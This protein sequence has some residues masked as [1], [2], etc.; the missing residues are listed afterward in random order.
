MYLSGSKSTLHNLRDGFQKQLHRSQCTC[1]QCFEEKIWYYGELNRPKGA[2][3]CKVGA[4]AGIVGAGVAALFVAASN[5]AVVSFPKS[6]GGYWSEGAD[7]AKAIGRCVFSD[8]NVHPTYSCEILHKKILSLCATSAYYE[9]HIG[10]SSGG[11][12][13]YLSTPESAEVSYPQRV[14]YFLSDGQFHDGRNYYKQSVFCSSHGKETPIKNGNRTV[15]CW[16]SDLR[17]LSS[18]RSKVYFPGHDTSE[19]R[20]S[21]SLLYPGD[22][23]IRAR[24]QLFELRPNRSRRKLISL[25]AP[26]LERT[27]NV[28]FSP[29]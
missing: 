8:K 6:N 17:H 19:S 3:N 7:I 23:D 9:D 26:E 12:S 21:I 4:I 15:D 22:P 27:Y 2:D 29:L 18:F 5:E 20:G 10:I 25:G 24:G 28:H 1:G 11:S 16:C 13:I 14:Q